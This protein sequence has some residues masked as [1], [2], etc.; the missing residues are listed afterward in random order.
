MTMTDY[1]TINIPISVEAHNYAKKFA[2]QQLKL[3]KKTQVYLNTL[4]VYAVDNFLKMMDIQTD[5]EYSD[6]WNP[7]IRC[8]HNVA[9]LAIMNVGKLECRFVLPEQEKIKLPPEVLEDRIGYLFVR[10]EESLQSGEILGF[11]PIYEPDEMP[12][13]V[14]IDELEDIEILFESLQGL[15]SGNNALVGDIDPVFARV[16][17]RLEIEDLTNTIA[18]LEWSYRTK[19]YYEWQAAATNFFETYLGL[20]ERVLADN[21]MEIV[22]DK[23]KENENVQLRDLAEDLMNKL[24]EIWEKGNKNF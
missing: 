6:S 10:L 8:Y 16:K 3:E 9:D 19:K 18:H 13:E 12:E 2:A 1:E 17:Y 14:E 5:L 20:G 23:Y 22:K 21:F 24:V 7:V 4:M 15:E 11:L